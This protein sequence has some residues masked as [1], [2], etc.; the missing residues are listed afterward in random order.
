MR[1]IERFA[2]D[3]EFQGRFAAIKWSP[4]IELRA[5]DGAAFHRPNT[6]ARRFSK[7]SLATNDLTALDRV[8]EHPVPHSHYA[9][10]LEPIS[11]SNH[12]RFCYRRSFWAWAIT[13]VL[14][15][16][17]SIFWL[18]LYLPHI[19]IEIL[20]SSPRAGQ[21]PSFS[22]SNNGFLSIFD[23]RALMFGLR[24]Q[25][26]NGTSKFTAIG[27]IVSEGTKANVIEAGRSIEFVASVT[28]TF[29]TIDSDVEAT[30]T[31]RPAF[32]WRRSYACARF[33]LGVDQNGVA[34]WLRKDPYACDVA[35]ACALR[36]TGVDMSDPAHPRCSPAK[37]K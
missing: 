36:H 2:D 30:V 21:P 7:V 11:T 25:I 29:V 33:T 34:A 37:G 22:I 12:M 13:A 5:G 4:S 8:V 24:V 3:R 26:A 15:V 1:G 35:V 19:D 6:R 31:F 14:A 9:I 27:L 28:N 10:L 32:S 17:G 18:P 16:A 20:Q 23:V